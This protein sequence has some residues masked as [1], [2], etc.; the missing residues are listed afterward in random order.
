MEVDKPR[1]NN[2]RLEEEG[3]RRDTLE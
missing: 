2:K 3:Q 1:T